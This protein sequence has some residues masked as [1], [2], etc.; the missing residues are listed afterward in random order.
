MCAHDEER[1]CKYYVFY[2][3]NVFSNLCTLCRLVGGWSIWSVV[4]GWLVG[5]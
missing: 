5:W 2:V 4:G 1:D 3:L